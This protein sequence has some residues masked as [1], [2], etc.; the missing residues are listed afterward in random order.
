M[1]VAARVLLVPT[2]GLGLWPTSRHDSLTSEGQKEGGNEILR[3]QVRD[4]N[5]STAR[6]GGGSF[7]R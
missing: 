7:Q 6:S 2:L 1:A 3:L 5:I 4:N